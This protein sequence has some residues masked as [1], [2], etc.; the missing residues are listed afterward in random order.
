MSWTLVEIGGGASCGIVP[1]RAALVMGS[2]GMVLSTL[3]VTYSVVET[4]EAAGRESN[5]RGGREV[6]VTTVKQVEERVLQDFCPHLQVLEV[7]SSFLKEVRYMGYHTMTGLME[8]T[9][10]PPTTAFAIFPIP[11]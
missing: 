10:S 8:L 9:A 1:T 7:G 5:G 6:Q 11:D 4:L 3:K 2:K